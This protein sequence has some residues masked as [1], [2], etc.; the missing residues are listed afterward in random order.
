M[1]LQAL[2]L[3][4]ESLQAWFATWRQEEEN[5]EESISVQEEASLVLTIWTEEEGMKREVELVVEENTAVEENTIAQ[6]SAAATKAAMMVDPN[7]KIASPAGSCSS[8]RS[9]H[10]DTSRRGQRTSISK[11]KTNRMLH[12]PHP[13]DPFSVPLA[14]GTMVSLSYTHYQLSSHALPL[15]C[16]WASF[17]LL[18]L[19]ALP[20]LAH[21]PLS[22]LD[23]CREWRERWRERQSQQVQQT[24]P[25][26]VATSS[27]WSGTK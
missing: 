1:G 4:Q 19:W 26:C 12:P 11:L 5:L 17:L 8:T 10:T 14:L 3:G 6:G 27:Y 18:F 20:F 22:L 9:L 25:R 24:L 15:S 21:V 7:L 13:E 2:V 16:L 23:E